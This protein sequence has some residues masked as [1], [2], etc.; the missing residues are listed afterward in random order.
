M[1]KL[2][3]TLY[4][5]LGMLVMSI[6]YTTV[7][8]ALATQANKQL[9]AYYNDIKILIDRDLIT[10]KDVNGKD[11]EPFIVDGTTYLPIRAITEALNKDVEWDG[12][13]Q[14]VNIYTKSEPITADEV[15]KTF[16]ETCL[17]L[18]TL[19]DCTINSVEHD[20]D[21]TWIVSFNVLPKAGQD[22]WIAGNGEYG[23]NGWIVNKTQY[24]YVV[25]TEGVVNLKVLGTSL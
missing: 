3:R 15:G 21:N 18:G 5:L 16:V 11:V 17:A 13:T 6:L 4:I 14:T 19:Q 25:K 9:D 12:T 7:V 23:E 2:S 1:K 22:E 20:S 24:I 10:P 8:P